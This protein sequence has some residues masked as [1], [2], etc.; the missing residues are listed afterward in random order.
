MAYS[1]IQEIKV[2]NLEMFISAINSYEKKFNYKWFR[3][4]P[5][6][7]KKDEDIKWSLIPK[8][9]VYSGESC[10]LFRK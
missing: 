9:Y 6:V 2:I 7:K 3:G 8:L 5:G 1:K 4:Q 10:H